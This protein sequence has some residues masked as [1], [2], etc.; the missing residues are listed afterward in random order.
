MVDLYEEILVKK[1]RPSACIRIVSFYMQ[2]SPSTPS[3]IP[4]RYI[5]HMHKNT[6]KLTCSCTYTYILKHT[7]TQTHKNIHT[8]MPWCIDILVSKPRCIGGGGL[9]YFIHQL[10]TH[11]HTNTLSHMHSHIYTLIH[12]H[13]DTNTHTHT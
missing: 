11:T 4:L 1:C 13:T 5:G 8:L 12:T 3:F 9:L 7:H 2:F 10:H 6:H